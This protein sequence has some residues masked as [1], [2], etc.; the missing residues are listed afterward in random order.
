[1]IYKHILAATAAMLV[2]PVAAQAETVVHSTTETTTTLPS[3]YKETTVLKGYKV[4]TKQPK[5]SSAPV[6]EK[7]Y[8]HKGTVFIPA[9]QVGM[10]PVAPNGVIVQENEFVFEKSY[11]GPTTFNE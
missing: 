8:H 10:V 9:D 1:M 6:I 7:T 11:K 4:T 5:G 3:G 2:F